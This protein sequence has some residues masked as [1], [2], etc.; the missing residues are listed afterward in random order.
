M[1]YCV[2]CGNEM[3]EEARFCPKCGQDQTQSVMTNDTVQQ[4]IS[5]GKNYASYFVEK[6]GKPTLTIDQASNYFGYVTM[7]LFALTQTLVI[8]SEM[9]RWSSVFDSI[10]ALTLPSSGNFYSLG[11]ADFLRIFIYALLFL[12]VSLGVTFF[13]VNYVLK[14]NVSLNDFMNKF[15]TVFSGIIIISFVISMGALIDLTPAWLSAIALG[16]GF[17][18]TVIAI[19]FMIA[20]RE[21]YLETTNWTPF[22][23]VT[24]TLALIGLVDFV[25][26]QLLS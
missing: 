10:L 20:K 14:I 23:S 24:L 4:T 25:I 18:V 11:L 15:A 21:N 22:Y 5:A 2:K 16:A 9:K 7:L 3:K 6:L 26:I 13:V 12:A 1:K 17:F 8:F 19:I